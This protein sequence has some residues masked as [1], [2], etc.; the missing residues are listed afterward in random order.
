M[1]YIWILMLLG[2][3]VIWLISSIMDV[4]RTVIH[5]KKYRRYGGIGDF[6]SC[7]IDELGDHTTGFIVLHI[8]VLFIESLN[9]WMKFKMGG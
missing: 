9:A 3:Y 8:F 2:I 6:I 5:V 1:R 4:V 7:I